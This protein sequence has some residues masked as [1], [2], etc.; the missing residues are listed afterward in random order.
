MSTRT[1]IAHIVA[2]VGD[3]TPG[4]AEHIIGFLA[5]YLADYLSDRAINEDTIAAGLAKFEEMNLAALRLL[6]HTAE[7]NPN[8]EKFSN[9]LGYAVLGRIQELS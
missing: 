5:D 3:I 4:A 8:R 9:A 7:E 1:A 2:D 6:D